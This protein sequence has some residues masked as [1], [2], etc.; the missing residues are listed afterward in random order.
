MCC[1]LTT[2]PPSIL[3]RMCA[4]TSKYYIDVNRVTDFSCH[5]RNTRTHRLYSYS[6]LL[7]SVWFCFIYQFCLK[8]EWFMSDI[9]CT[10]FLNV[11]II[12]FN[13]TS[14]NS[15]LIL[16]RNHKKSVCHFNLCVAFNVYTFWLSL[17]RVDGLTLFIHVII[18][19]YHI[20]SSYKMNVLL[21]LN[22]LRK[23]FCIFISFYHISPKTSQMN[24]YS[25]VL[26]LLLICLYILEYKWKYL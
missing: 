1:K 22:L 13:I 25:L 12:S 8:Y 26:L 14:S 15:Q 23:R 9:Y 18:V 24:F 10:H 2:Y 20:Y 4:K 17:K 3:I 6:F 11:S 5:T 7:L 19:G 21:Y 16:L